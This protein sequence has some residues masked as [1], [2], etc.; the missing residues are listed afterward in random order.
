MR[1]NS[2]LLML[3]FGFGFWKSRH[4]IKISV[5]PQLRQTIELRFIT[6]RNNLH[7]RINCCNISSME[8]SGQNKI[9]EIV[10]LKLVRRTLYPASY[11][12]NIFFNFVNWNTKLLL[13]K[14]FGLNYLEK[15]ERSSDLT[16]WKRTQ[17]V[18][19]QN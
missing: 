17:K 19:T 7:L 1:V 12:Q 15:F 8:K 14:L 9:T 10:C 2:Q 4:N 13:W 11:H 3:I 16:A 5:V 18:M 6:V